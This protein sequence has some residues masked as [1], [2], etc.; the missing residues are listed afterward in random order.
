MEKFIKRE[1]D[2]TYKIKRQSLESDKPGIRIPA[3][4]VS[5]DRT[6]LGKS[7]NLSHHPF[8]QPLLGGKIPAV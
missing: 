4:S 7:L 1:V 3:L 6:W 5:R 2:L 8:P